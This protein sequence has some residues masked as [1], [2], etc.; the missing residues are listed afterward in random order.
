MRF[1]Y[2]YFIFALFFLSDVYTYRWFLNTIANHSTIYRWAYW[3]VSILVYMTLFYVIYLNSH[4]AIVNAT[5]GYNLMVGI[6]FAFLIAKVIMGAIFF[7]GDI[8]RIF[9]YIFEKVLSVEMETKGWRQVVSYISLSVGI[10]LITSLVYG[11]V[12]GKYNFK[13]HEQTIASSKIPENFDGYRIVQLSDAHLGTFDRMKPVEKVVQRI[14]DLNPDLIVFTGDLVNFRASEAKK[15]IRI[16]SQLDAKD[17]KYTIMGNH[18]YEM[19]RHR[20]SAFYEEDKEA[21]LE[22]LEKKMGFRWLKNE[23]ILLKKR[24]QTIGLGGV[25]NWG[26]PPFPQLGDVDKAFEHMDQSTFK[27]LLSHDPSYWEEVVAN[28]VPKVDLTLS[29]HTHGMQFGIEIGSFKWS[30]VKYIYPKWAGMYE[31]NGV[32][33]Y[34]NR[35][36]G[37]IGYPGRLGIWPEVTVFTLKHK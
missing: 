37:S 23:S 22:V 2:F 31:K 18:D 32:Q 33:L 3:F 1:I 26:R 29:G 24:E 20:Q 9:A 11:V 14:N 35:G 10:T 5:L 12:W 15:F 13:F 34:V 6:V 17:G 4:E 25:E 19:A 8:G 16:F 36:F 28:N 30:P 21:L 7:V 27:I